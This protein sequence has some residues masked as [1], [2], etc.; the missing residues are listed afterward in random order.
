MRR[1]VSRMWEA[2]RKGDLVLLLLCVVTTAFGCLMIASTTTATVSGPVRYLAVQI[3]ASVAGIL[4]YVA[5]SSVDAEFFS[6]HRMSMVVIN[7]V[8]LLLLIPFGET[9]AGN[10]SWL[11]FPFLP[12]NIQPAEICK[13][14]YVLIMASVMNSNQNR[15]SSIPSVLQML[16][17][18]FILFGL[19]VVISGDL[20]VS[21]I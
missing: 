5:M 3:G 21:L 9:I 8:L 20:G 15:L 10:R 1:F 11:N 14:T 2:F 4:A 7:T 19:N 13:I 18:L 12:F 6:E 16:F 17:H